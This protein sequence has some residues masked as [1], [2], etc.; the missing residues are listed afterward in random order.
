[1]ERDG[2]VSFA[3]CGM[4][5]FIGGEIVDRA[6]LVVASAQLLRTRFRIDVRERSEAVAIDRVARTVKVRRLVDGTEYELSWDRLI[7]SPGAAAIV[8]PL[9]GVHAE[10]VYSLRNLLDMDR[11]RAAVDAAPVGARRAIVAG[12]GF[13]GLEMAEQLVRRGFAVQLVELQ[14]QVLP[15]FDADLAVAIQEEL[16][17]NGV[18]VWLGRGLQAVCEQGGRVQGVTLSDGTA[19]PADLVILGIGVRPNVGLAVACGLELGPAGGIR[20]NEFLQTSDPLIYAAGDAVEYPWGPSGGTARV[21]LAGPANRAGRLA[22]QHAV[23]GVSAALRPV[24]GTSIVRVFGQ[25]AAMTGL[26]VR[27]ARRAGIACRS[28]T[29][30]AG[31]HAGYFPGASMLTLKLVYESGTGRLLGAQA[32]GADGVDKR[33]DVLATVLSFGGQCARCGGSGF[34]LRTAFRFGSGSAAS[35]GFCGLQ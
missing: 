13:I 15:P 10:G 31:Q 28:A 6:K 21:A 17:R 24:Q 16:V 9:P 29:V 2:D 7:L 18:Q 23:S 4:P 25:T 5:Y 19:L 12:A 32:T 1:L 34:V 14:P 30:I 11:I 20:V 22:G 26:S 33:I 35:G 3:N 27:A 8:P